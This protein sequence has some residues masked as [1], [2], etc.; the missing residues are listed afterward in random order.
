MQVIDVATTADANAL[1]ALVAQMDAQLGYPR[2]AGGT[3]GGGVFA[4]PNQ[5]IVAHYTIK[6]AHPTQAGRYCLE[7]TGE[8]VAPIVASITNAAKAAVAAGTATAA[9]ASIAALPPVA[10]RDASWVPPGP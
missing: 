1:D 5:T 8:V 10:E 7:V 2:S 9:Q 4:P 6:K 3:E